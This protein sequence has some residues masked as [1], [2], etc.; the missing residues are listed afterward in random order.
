MLLAI[1]AR[2]SRVTLPGLRVMQPLK[3]VSSVLTTS[4]TRSTGSCQGSWT[5]PQDPI[6]EEPRSSQPAQA[7][8]PPRASQR[9]V[10]AQ[11]FP[12][13]DRHLSLASMLRQ[14]TLSPTASLFQQL[15][16]IGEKLDSC[17]HAISF[18]YLALDFW[19][20]TSSSRMNTPHTVTPKEHSSCLIRPLILPL[21]S[22]RRCRS[23]Q[24][25]EDYYYQQSRLQNARV[26]LQVGG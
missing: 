8:S 4:K 22:I 10:V 21:L 26:G 14:R 9:W 6:Q 23:P 19:A 3:N 11:N 13:A 17:Y 5:I 12:T 15:V 18:L 7:D 20:V 1:S 2:S 24:V 16:S 25:I